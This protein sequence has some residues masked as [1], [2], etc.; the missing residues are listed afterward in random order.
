MVFSGP[1]A[2]RRPS[3]KPTRNSANFF[4]GVGTA[5]R[6]ALCMDD[7]LLPARAPRAPHA[8][9][10]PI[11][12]HAFVKA[13]S[14]TLDITAISTAFPL[15]DSVEAVSVAVVSC[16]PSASEGGVDEQGV[17]RW[18]ITYVVITDEPQDGPL[19]AMTASGIPRFFARYSFGNEQDRGAHRGACQAQLRSVDK[20][21][22][23]WHVTATFSSRASDR[24]PDEALVDDPLLLPAEVSGD[25][26]TTLVPVTKDKD[27]NRVAN[28]IGDPF[29]GASRTSSNRT[30]TISK[31]YGDSSIIANLENY[32]DCV[33]SAPFFGKGPRYWRLSRAPWK[34]QY[35]GSGWPYYRVTFEFE[36]NKDT[37]DFMPENRGWNY[38]RD[39][40]IRPVESREGIQ[41]H[42]PAA[43]GMDGELL[44][45]SDPPIV[46]DG[47]GDNPSPFRLYHER[48]FATL[49]IPINYGMR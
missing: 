38:L 40:Y 23:L 25:F 39:G 11:H 1:G 5:F 27:G 26:T 9:I 16:E 6:F 8:A 36:C 2:P 4:R 24:P 7:P 37:W 22:K 13:T 3:V 30:L 12:S 18:T 28:T 14:S 20:S 43:L 17:R 42:T 33:N 34:E 29:D 35:R 47:I 15:T 49:G 19:I 44:G 48:N 10:P 41:L 21:R 45:P 32:L 31:N 46:F